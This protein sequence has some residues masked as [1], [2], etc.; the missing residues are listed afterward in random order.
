MKVSEWVNQYPRQL[1]IV[2]PED[3]LEKV[4]ELMLSGEGIREVYV[5]SAS[6]YLCGCINYKKLAA[7]LMIHHLPIH[8]PR[9][10]MDR[11]AGG[12]AHE[13]MD[14][15]IVSCQMRE[16]LDDVIFRQIEHEIE[17]MPVL[18]ELEH[19]VGVIHQRDVVRYLSKEALGV[20]IL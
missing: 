2:K 16:Y 6:G 19:V 5:Q 3:T 7:M 10:M 14:S 9:Q 20:D 8:T 13:V 17:D 1:M 11:V 4:T 12:V 15:H 18:N